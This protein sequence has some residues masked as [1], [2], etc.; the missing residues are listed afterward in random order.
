MKKAK[1]SY[2]K[3]LQ[4][5]IPVHSLE[6]DALELYRA[7]LASPDEEE[8]RLGT[9]RLLERLCELGSLR[10]IAQ[11]ESD[12]AVRRTYRNLSSLD[13]IAITLPAS[14]PSAAPPPVS[15]PVPHDIEVALPDVERL[16]PRAVLDAVAASS[17]RTDL[18][19]ALSHLYDFLKESIGY[20]RIALFVSRAVLS[21]HAGALTELEDICRW[22][23]EER[24]CPSH[25]SKKVEEEGETLVVQDLT[26]DSR[27]SKYR[28]ESGLTSVVVAPLKAEAYVYGVVEVWSKKRAAFDRE[29]VAL[30]E[31]V[32]GFAG[33]LI[34]RRLEVEELI[35]IDQ[36]TEIHN[37]R[38][39][40]E[41]LVRETERC[42]RSGRSLAL[43]MIDIDHFKLVNDTLG[44]AA[45]D[46][47]LRQSAR[48]LLYNARQ[49]DIVARY[50]GEEF[51]VIL[52]GVT[53]ESA[54]TVAERIRSSIEHHRFNTGVDAKP[55]W[56][57]T[58]SIGGA[59]YPLD[60]RSRDELIDKADRIALY[61]AK[62]RG[63]NR[64]VFWQD[65]Q[66]G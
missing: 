43:L 36:T 37:R 5:L 1:A 11:S 60:A 40:D 4:Q 15:P 9:V 6:G 58:V 7:V 25:V 49:V 46:S 16:L 14:V 30:I 62:H 41:Q 3:L 51:A 21:T 63:K 29:A 66:S 17:R 31:F 45:G 38:Y 34:K 42:R 44:H 32:A 57:L 65:T 13:T 10:R 59:L 54:L 20:D 24:F 53:R 35:F 28:G 52:P 12:G 56:D 22:P 33:G 26:A 47:I 55:V 61:T 64:V 8:L 19:G 27:F 48:V 18:S 2:R 50:G 23:R 39:F